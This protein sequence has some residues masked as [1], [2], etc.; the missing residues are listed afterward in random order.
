MIYEAASAILYKPDFKVDSAAGL[1]PGRNAFGPDRPTHS[2]PKKM[3]LVKI[4]GFLE[5]I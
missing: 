3:L 5:E 1:G 4:G 2:G